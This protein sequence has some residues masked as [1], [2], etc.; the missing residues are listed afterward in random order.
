ME[1]K[2]LPKETQGKAW[3]LPEELS[4]YHDPQEVPGVDLLTSR[5]RRFHDCLD[6]ALERHRDKEDDELFQVAVL[7]DLANGCRQMGL[8]QEFCVRMA[9]FSYVFTG[10]AE[11]I[12][13]VF[14]T[15]YLRQQLKTIPLKFMTKSALLTFKT[16]A[17][18]REHFLF[19]LNE[20]TG[21]PEF[22][23]R[24]VAYSFQP[25][26]Q[27]AR[28]TMSIN[29]LK[30]G[31]DSWDKDLNRYIDSNLI[32]RYNPL[33]D[34]LTHLAPWDG[35]DRI[36]P[37]AQ[38]VKTDNPHWPH[39]F[40]LWMRSMVAQWLGKSRQHGNAIVPLLIGPQGSGKTTFCRRLLPEDLQTYYND[41]LSMKNDNDIFTAMSS[42]ALINLD[43]F[44]AMSKSQQPILKYLLTKHDVKMR[45]P[46]GKVVEQRRRYA[47]FMA[48]TNNLRPLT[49]PT[50][51]RRFVCVYADT[52]DNSG[53]LG[54]NQIFA[55]LVQEVRDKQRYWLTDHENA[56][57][58]EQ[59]ARFQQ[60]NDY[61]S[62]LSLLF[63]P[64]EATEADAPYMTLSDVIALISS[65]FPTF[66][67]TNNS[68]VEVG[69]ML[70]TMGYEAK[71]ITA[72]MIYRLQKR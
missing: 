8:E 34:Y 38:R 9:G 58:I 57:L 63:L 49:D 23:H 5:V 25:L 4:D 13:T 31:V 35:K 11:L 43:E 46:Y 21:V 61:Q 17:Y 7:E 15:A 16:E 66:R 62:M 51:S 56:Q 41:R 60:V 54:H 45:P 64:P 26:D 20:L 2:T 40:H 55:Q 67:L 3:S 22:K 28:N 33:E 19:R 27:A 6:D 72:G 68:R 47:S 44:D 10:K 71:R 52:I 70:K 18:L 59:N 42:Y 32:P 30:A 36:T 12:K 69:R 39:L 29:A 53:R 24:G 65:S 37:L 14:R 1:E 48:T 50:G